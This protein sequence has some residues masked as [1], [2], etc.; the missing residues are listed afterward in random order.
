M[1]RFRP[2]NSFYDSSPAYR[3]M[4]R[5]CGGDAG[6]AV[7]YGDRLGNTSEIR[8]SHTSSGE[9]G[10]GVS[11]ARLAPRSQPILWPFHI[12]SVS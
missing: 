10:E 3:Y 1:E 7:S 9:H 2:L 11:V 12:K 4:S 8:D 6:V 5:G